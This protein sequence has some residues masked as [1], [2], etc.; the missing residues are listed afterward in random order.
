[1]IGTSTYARIII[2]PALICMAGCQGELTKGKLYMRDGND[3]EALQ[4]LQQAL[5]KQ[6]ADPE[7]P[8]LI[9]TIHARRGDYERMNRAFERSLA[10]GDDHFVGID[11]Q[12]TEYFNSEYNRGVN[13]LQAPAAD[14]AAAI[15]AFQAATLIDGGQAAGWRNLGYSYF[16][17]DSLSAATTAYRVAAAVD[18]E[19]P[20][21]WFDL[22]TA[23]LA[24][25]W[26]AEAATSFERL[27]ELD[28]HHDDGLRSLARAQTGMGDIA[29]V[30]ATYRGLLTTA[31]GDQTAHYNLG[32]LYWQQEAYDEAIAAYEMAVAL[33]PHDDDALH[34][35]A[36]T[37]I[38]KDDTENALP[39]LRQLVERMPNNAILWRELGRIYLLRGEREESERAFARE[40]ALSTEE[41]SG[42]GR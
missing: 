22:G 17:L 24:G 11:R 16:K 40:Q 4:Y 18:A 12:R 38:V 31:P 29:A 8:F 9:G 21:S 23:Q 7:V 15:E 27:I 37:Y 13:I 3:E 14:Y 34:N 41:G 25:Q 10:L 1:M 39:L 20:T 30:I 5:A 35:L 6:P 33:N 19:N 2:I 32:N 28:P 42:F 36:L 26:Y